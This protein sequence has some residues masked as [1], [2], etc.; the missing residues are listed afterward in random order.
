MTSLAAAIVDAMMMSHRYSPFVVGLYR[1]FDGRRDRNH[2][3]EKSCQPMQIP[4]NMSIADSS[5]A[6]SSL[7][8]LSRPMDKM[9]AGTVLSVS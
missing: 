1:G 9:N 5:V 6:H 8:R 2:Q 7:A 4:A 3:P